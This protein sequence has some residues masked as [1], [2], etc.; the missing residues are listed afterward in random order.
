MRSVGDVSRSAFEGPGIDA[1]EEEKQEEEGVRHGDV[2]TVSG[3][4]ATNDRSARSPEFQ[5]FESGN[6]YWEPP[7]TMKRSSI[8]RSARQRAMQ[9]P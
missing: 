5:D 4:V 6:T 7:P 3:V 9:Q 8:R 2:S 1:E